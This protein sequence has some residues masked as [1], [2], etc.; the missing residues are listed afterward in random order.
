MEC[1]FVAM[2]YTALKMKKTFH[3]GPLCASIATRAVFIYN[4][5]V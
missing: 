5:T 3:L 1:G 4:Y 2:R